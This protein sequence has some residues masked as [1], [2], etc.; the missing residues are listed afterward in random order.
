MKHFD[1]D[2]QE[3]FLSDRNGDTDNASFL[4]SKFHDGNVNFSIFLH[5]LNI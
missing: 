4:Y 3:Q 1:L 5:Y 2:E